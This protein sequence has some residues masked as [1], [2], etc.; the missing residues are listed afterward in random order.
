VTPEDRLALARA[1]TKIIQ[2]DAEA[3]GRVAYT[4]VHR[5]IELA[6]AAGLAAGTA[7]AARHVATD[8]GLEPDDAGRLARE[9]EALLQPQPC[10]CK[11]CKAGVGHYAPLSSPPG[12]Q[13]DQMTY[14]AFHRLWTWAVGLPGYDKSAWKEVEAAL[15]DLKTRTRKPDLGGTCDMPECAHRWADDTGIQK[16]CLDC[17]VYKDCKCQ[18]VEEG[19]PPP[20]PPHDLSDGDGICIKC[21][22]TP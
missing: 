13:E 5:Y 2:A 1:A 9:I 20:C 7:M 11:R 4:V 22:G 8:T 10:G 18:R 3:Y 12:A 15:F 19:V 17:M 6:Y 14:Y 21:G 16:F